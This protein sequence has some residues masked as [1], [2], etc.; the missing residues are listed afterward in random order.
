MFATSVLSV[1]GTLCAVRWAGMPL[2]VKHPCTGA[3]A[4][5]SVV[6]LADP[7]VRNGEVGLALAD[8]DARAR[9]QWLA[10]MFSSIPAQYA[11]I[12]C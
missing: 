4:A 5:A 12:P 7:Q 11:V 1:M 6:T 3:M 8:S 10:Q 9:A 2:R